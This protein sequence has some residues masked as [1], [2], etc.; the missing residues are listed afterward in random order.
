MSRDNPSAYAQTLKELN[1]EVE[2][3][4]R[5]DR[6]ATRLLRDLL[7]TVEMLVQDDSEE[8]RET[9]TFLEGQS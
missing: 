6:E 8:Q 4:R 3:L 5:R 7:R 2:R 9:R 1:D